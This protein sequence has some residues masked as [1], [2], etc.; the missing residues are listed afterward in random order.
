MWNRERL[1]DMVK[2]VLRDL[3][4]VAVSNRRPYVHARVDGEVRCHVPPSGL[5]MD[6]IRR[7]AKRA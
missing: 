7:V 2:D 4:L 3:A 5:T 1:H 6:Y